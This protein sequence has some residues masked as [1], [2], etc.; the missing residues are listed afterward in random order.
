MRLAELFHSNAVHMPVLKKKDIP[1]TYICIFDM[2]MYIVDP[3]GVFKRS[4]MMF[5]IVQV[6]NISVM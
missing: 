2:Y 5:C 3:V 1:K 4:K 6:V